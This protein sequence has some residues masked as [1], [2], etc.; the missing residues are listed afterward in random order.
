MFKKI[1]S[2]T[3]PPRMAVALIIMLIFL[4][5]MFSG[6]I[7][8]ENSGST[9]NVVINLSSEAMNASL[10]LA[11]TWLISNL[12][13][14]GYFNY[15]YD[16]EKEE[17][18]DKNNMIRQLMASRILA[19]MSQMN[20][21]LEELHQKNLDYIFEHWYKEDNET[22]HGYIY[23]DEKS[24]LGAI[25]MGLR[26]LVYSPFF[27]NYREN[28]TKLANTILYLQNDTDGSFEPWFIEPV[29]D[30]DKSYLLTFYSGEAILI[31]VEMYSKTGN[32]TYLNA[33]IKS[34][35][36]YLGKY[37]TNLEENYY[38]A[39]V[40]WHTQSLNK[41]YKITGEQKYADAIM[42]LNDKLLEIQDTSNNSTLGRFYDPSHPEYGT[43]HSSSDGI[44]VEGLA[45]AYEIAS[46]TNDTK[47]QD[48]Y[49][50]GIILGVHNLINLQYN[51]SDKKTN[52]A[53]R[54]SNDDYRLR[55]DTTQHTID[56]FGKI[57]DVFDG[58]WKYVYDSKSGI[59][60]E[61]G[62]N[63][64]E[65]PSESVWYA[66]GI[67]TILSIVLLFA[68]YFIVRKKEHN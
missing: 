12:R 37:V 2:K 16:P 54:Y 18:S 47:H 20:S 62:P 44:Y 9:K 63:E 29:Y 6:C 28:A 4:S 41:L 13:E 67:G 19:E 27:D 48:K 24:K 52:G 60:V 17:Y 50:T 11:E 33:A 1:F 30:Y 15:I 7:R 51:N 57:L 64:E 56:A 3:I 25:A 53:I 49:K 8:K 21:S 45:Y 55:I 39:Y 36:F 59:L 65:L 23:Y 34:Q 26:T 40:P 61:Y 31:L 68:I 42:I 38:P 10:D 46:L 58:G 66:L 32:A 43:P 5:S 22:G 14:E 35:D